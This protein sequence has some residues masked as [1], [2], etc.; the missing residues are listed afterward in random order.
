MEPG[1]EL[2]DEWDDACAEWGLEFVHV[3]A[4]RRGGSGPGDHGEERK[5]EFGGKYAFIF[6]P[7]LFFNPFPNRVFD[8]RRFGPVQMQGRFLTIL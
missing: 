5:N 3:L 2:L 4:T 1:S 6:L 8:V 7:P